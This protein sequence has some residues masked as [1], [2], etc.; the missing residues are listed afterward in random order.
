MLLKRMFTDAFHNGDIT[1]NPCPIMH[2]GG[3]EPSEKMALTDDQTKIL[4]DS[5]KETRAYLFCMIALYTGMRLE[6][7]YRRRVDLSH[8]E[9]TRRK[10]EHC[11]PAHDRSCAYQ[12][13]E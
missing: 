12:Y 11:N 13:S 3:K 4:L 9:H 2:N 5:I 6:S 1:E 7:G 10:S 8:R